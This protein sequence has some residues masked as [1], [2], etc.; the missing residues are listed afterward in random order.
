MAELSKSV[1]IVETKY[2]TFANS[3]NELILESGEKLG[4]ITLAYE[5]YGKLNDQKSNA[6][7]ILHALSGESFIGCFNDTFKFFR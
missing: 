2:F 5:T 7:L 4:P 6:V 1:G 3:P